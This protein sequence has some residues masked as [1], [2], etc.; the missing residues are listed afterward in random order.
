MIVDGMIT[1]EEILRR[2]WLIRRRIND[3]SL[4]SEYGWVCTMVQDEDPR[5]CTFKGYV[6][7][8]AY[9]F[10]SEDYQA[11]ERIARQLKFARGGYERVFTNGR[12]R[13]AHEVNDEIA[14]KTG[15]QEGL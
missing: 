14:Q 15:D 4:T 9:P 3:D 12:L 2:S 6:A 7:R 1:V 13:V 5:R 8:D 10:K 11:L